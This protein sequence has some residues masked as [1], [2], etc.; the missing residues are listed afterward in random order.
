MNIKIDLT[1]KEQSKT[2]ELFHI[3]EFNDRHENEKAYV[4]NVEHNE[5]GSSFNLNIDEDFYVEVYDIALKYRSQIMAFFYAIKSFT[6]LLGGIKKDFQKLAEK[7][8]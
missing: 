3:K 5:D 4:L 6:E 7:W 1:S 2:V 8:K